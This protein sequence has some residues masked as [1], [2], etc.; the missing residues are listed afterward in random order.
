MESESVIPEK[1]ISDRLKQSGVTYGQIVQ[2]GNDMFD[3][4]Y[5]LAKSK[6]PNISDDLIWRNL[7]TLDRLHLYHITCQLCMSIEQCPS[8]DGTRMTGKMAADGVITICQEPC[9]QGFKVPKGET[10]AQVE[11]R[12]ERSWRRK[13]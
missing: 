2:A 11:Q 12:A 8:F 3:R 9:P 1:L 7:A 13:E 10:V 5:D 4:V 6:W